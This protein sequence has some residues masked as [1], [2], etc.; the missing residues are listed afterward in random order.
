MRRKFALILCGFCFSIFIF[1][2]F[3]LNHSISSDK[4]VSFLNI[5]CPC[6]D[7]VTRTKLGR[8]RLTYEWPFLVQKT[9]FQSIAVN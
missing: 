3:L 4:N 8:S 6:T 2:Y 7:K 9:V 1:I 5:D